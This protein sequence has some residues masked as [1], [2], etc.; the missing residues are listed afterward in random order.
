MGRAAHVFVSSDSLPTRHRPFPPHNRRPVIAGSN[1]GPASLA[2]AGSGPNLAL[3][4]EGI[5]VGHCGT[6]ARAARVISGSNGDDGDGEVLKMLEALALRK[7][8]EYELEKVL[9]P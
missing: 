1:R 4:P 8:A 5:I 7:R 6:S 3:L 9:R 2:E